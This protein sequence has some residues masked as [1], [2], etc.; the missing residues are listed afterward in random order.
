MQASTSPQTP[1]RDVSPRRG[2]GCQNPRSGAVDQPDQFRLD[3][4]SITHL[5][6]QVQCRP[7]CLASRAGDQDPLRTLAATG[8]A[9]SSAHPRKD[10]SRAARGNLADRAVRCP[11]RSLTRTRHR[12]PPAGT[13]GAAIGRCAVRPEHR[14]PGC[15]LRNH[16]STEGSMNHH[17]HGHGTPPVGCRRRTSRVRNE[18]SRARSTGALRARR[19]SMN[20]RIEDQ[21]DDAEQRIPICVQL[22]ESRTNP[23][24]V[25]GIGRP[26]G[27]RNPSG[28]RIATRHRAGDGQPTPPRR[29]RTRR[30][31]PQ[32]S[33]S[34]SGR[35][36]RWRSRSA[37]ATRGD[38][39]SR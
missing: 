24:L 23:S 11:A 30:S 39:Q 2:R 25:V 5:V 10:G 28:A 6:E 21:E 8:E 1:R 34:T 26:N 20:D 18:V 15:V 9:D 38:R 36:P 4:H 16:A 7:R 3:Q 14:V 13:T 22:F 31:G 12:S 19:A 33:G 35:S 27:A 29:T 17:R 32:N 37:Q